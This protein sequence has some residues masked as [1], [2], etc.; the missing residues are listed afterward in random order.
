MSDKVKMTKAEFVAMATRP[1]TIDELLFASVTCI[2]G[3]LTIFDFRNALIYFALNASDD[4]IDLLARL[5]L[6]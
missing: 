5:R 2:C 3:Q 4:E 6:S 1:R